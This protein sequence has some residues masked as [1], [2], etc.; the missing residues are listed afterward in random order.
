MKSGA[1][2]CSLI[3]LLLVLW[4]YAPKVI[5]ASGAA[6]A[7]APALAW[8]PA[9]QPTVHPPLPEDPSHLWLVPSRP[10]R[11]RGRSE[12]PAFAR[13]AQGVQLLQEGKAAAALPL[14]ATRNLSETLLANYASYYMALAELRLGRVDSARQALGALAA[15][16]PDGYLSQAVLMAQAEAAETANDFAAAGWIYDAL[17]TQKTVNPDQVW[18][19][20]GR[21]ALT[22]G[23]R[24]KASMA[25]RH[26][27]Y[28]FPLSDLSVTVGTELEGLSDVFDRGSRTVFDLDLGRAQ[29]L[30]GSRSYAEARAGFEALQA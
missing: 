16:Q 22:L 29:R 7:Q 25:F 15:R 14:L 30:F 11:G 9:L 21:T 28:E 19:R 3:T 6:R 2:S 8:P 27:Y 12:R 5:P 1:L 4:P 24:A 26:V 20:L 17:T 18:F 10:D 23:D 13:F